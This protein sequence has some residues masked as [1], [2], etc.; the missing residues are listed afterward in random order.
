MVNYL[1]GRSSHD[2]AQVLSERFGVSYF[3]SRRLVRT[4]ITFVEA[5]MEARAYEDLDIE[6][7][8]YVSVLDNRTT[9]LCQQ[10]DGKVYKVKERKAGVNYPPLHPFCRAT[11]IAHIS[12]EW[13]NKL[14]AEFLAEDLREQAVKV[15]PVITA[16]LQRVTNTV[17]AGLAGLENRFKSLDSLIRK[18]MT[19]AQAVNTTPGAVAERIN[20]ALRYTIIL[21]PKSFGRQYAQITQLLD[22]ADYRIL[23]VKNT[24]A[25]GSLYKGVNTIVEKAGQRFELQYHT[26]ESFELKNG[27]LHELYEE[28]R[29]PSTSADRRQEL[30][31]EMARLSSR[32]RAPKGIG[33][34]K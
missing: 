25:P 23:K 5:E 33:E 15:E 7:Y 1:T 27:V 13:D 9:I 31:K 2:M 24:W 16:D 10:H 29:L 17:R 8:E 30:E 34:V 32:L 6:E 22:T 18:I 19:G 20:D 12:G 3:N 21:S 4:E 11:T 14:W 26:H 28:F